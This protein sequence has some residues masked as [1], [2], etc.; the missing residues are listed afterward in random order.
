MRELPDRPGDPR[1]EDDVLDRRLIDACNGTFGAFEL[2]IEDG[3]G[4][5]DFFAFS[6]AA[7]AWEL[8]VRTYYCVASAFDATGFRLEITGTFE[9]G[10]EEAGERVTA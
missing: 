4:R 8:G 3:P 10:W 5:V 9:G 7:V 1:P 2:R 6:D